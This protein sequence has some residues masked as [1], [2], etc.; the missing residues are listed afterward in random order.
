LDLAPISPPYLFSSEVDYRA[1]LY[2]L[3]I[4]LITGIACG[5]APAIRNSGIDVY[6]AL[7]SGGLMAGPRRGRARSALVVVELALSTALVIGSLLMVKSFL[8]QQQIDYGY[9]ADG[10]LTARL[11]LDQDGYRE[12][13]ARVG[14]M[15]AALDRMEALPEVRSAA[16]TNRLPA[17]GGFVLGELEVEGRAVEDGER[18]PAKLQWVTSRYFEVLEIPLI[19]GRSLSQGEAREGAA[20]ALVSRSLSERLWPGLDPLGRRFRVS[21]AGEGDWLTVIGVAGDVD[22]GERMVQV[23]GPSRV[24]AYL[25]FFDA[26]DS[27]GSWNLVLRSDSSPETLAAS[28]RAELRVL[29]PGV[30]VSDILSMKQLIWELQWVTRMFGQ[31]MAMYA[32]MALLVAALG[33]YGVCADSVSRRTREI[34]VRSAL[35]AARGDLLRLAMKQGLVLG[36]LGIGLGLVLALGVTRFGA[37]MLLGVSTSD[38]TVFALVAVFLGIVSSL[39]TYF[40]ARRASRIDVVEA[41]R[42]E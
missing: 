40:P 37:S 6:E 1:M 36:A 14:F 27:V 2:T 21:V 26:P 34:A 42:A 20:V 39:A 4:A 7:K 12:A 16:A 8:N 3:V 22:V 10:L 13:R 29:A 25:P 32:G 41:L 9:R 33:A 15:S 31:M 35:G 5:A 18:V 11:S 38:P 19:S 28:M 24:H 17:S 30:P 23:G